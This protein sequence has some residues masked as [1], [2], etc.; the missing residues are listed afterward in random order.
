MKSIGMIN[1]GKEVRAA[2]MLCRLGSDGRMGLHY[3][4]CSYTQLN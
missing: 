4:I 1:L 2:S 3:I